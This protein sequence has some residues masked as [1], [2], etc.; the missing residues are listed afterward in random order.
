MLG[1]IIGN[2]IHIVKLTNQ[3]PEITIKTQVQTQV[4]VE[5]D[6]ESNY[7]YDELYCL[8]VAI[9]NEAGSNSCTDQ[10]REYVGYVI[11]NRVNDSRFPD[12]IRG[13]LEQPGQ[14]EGLGV[15]GVYF[16]KRAS[17]DTEQEALERAWSIAQ[18]VLE[19]KDNIP[20]PKNV[21]FQAEFK[22]G[23][24]VYKKIGNTYF[25]YAN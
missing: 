15:N 11:L 12:T 22:Q 1:I 16:S 24:N 8:A 5:V 20:I 18:K 6:K 17:H 25:C 19:N 14:Y 2:I 4:V 3:E 13:V 10:Q 7:T 21:V 9:Y 23:N